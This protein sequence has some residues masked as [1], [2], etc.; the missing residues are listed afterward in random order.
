MPR[1]SKAP[2]QVGRLPEN[3]YSFRLSFRPPYDWNAMLGFLAPRAIPG[4]EVVEAGSYRRSILLDGSEGWAEATL[5]QRNHTLAVRIQF[6][7]PC[8]VFFI[9]ERIRTMFDLDADPNEIAR[10]LGD[11]DTLA[12]LVKAAPGVRVP[13][14]WD[15]FELATR[16]IVG[17]QIS[18]KAATTLA[19]RVV[20]TFGRP[21]SA[22][23]GITHL[24]PGAEILAEA[25]L[26]RAGITQS[27]A[28]TIRTLARA[29]CEGRIGFEGIID[30]D[31]VLD[32]LR[33]IRGIGEW[34]AQYIAMRALG[35][36]DAFPTGDLGLV[37][38][39][40]AQNSGQLERRAEAWRPWRAYAAMYLWKSLVE[41][42]A[43]K[44]AH[45]A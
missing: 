13:G 34:T 17:Q 27:R 32:Q 45:W 44:P 25:D 28:E 6:P 5:D 21:I 2:G 7:D 16:A 43:L 41:S 24:F 19:G 10:C 26:R 15:G 11:D 29:V 42:S 23:G 4:V 9:V 30:A 1:R 22:P 12:M 14:C 8:T 38:A 18:V 40:G 3:Q 37:R 33:G 31:E 35:E 39:A 20:T 36:P